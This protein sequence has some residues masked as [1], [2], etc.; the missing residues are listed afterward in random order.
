MTKTR[1]KIVLSAVLLYIS[2]LILTVS[3]QTTQPSNANSQSS[4]NLIGQVIAVVGIVAIFSVIAYAGY[5]MV[6][7]WSSS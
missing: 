1:K 7:K 5:K 6:R 4:T 3:A 2:T